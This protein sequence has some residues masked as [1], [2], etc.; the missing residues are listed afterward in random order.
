M[1]LYLKVA[2]ISGGIILLFS[3]AV[4]FFSGDGS[5]KRMVTIS[6]VYSICRPDNYDVVCFGDADSKHGGLFCMP[7]SQVSGGACK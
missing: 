4:L 2:A 3:L 6:G 5:F 1:S 7:L